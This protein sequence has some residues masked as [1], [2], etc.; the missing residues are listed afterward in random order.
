MFNSWH[1]HGNHLS[2]ITPIPGTLC[3]LLTSEGTRH[4]YD[5]QRKIQLLMCIKIKINKS[6]FHFNLSMRSEYF[7]VFLYF[8]KPFDDLSLVIQISL[9]IFPVTC[10]QS[11]CDNNILHSW[12]GGWAHYDCNGVLFSL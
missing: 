6:N 8:H 7:E 4:M 9:M 10:M 5:T 1:A 12:H 2:P 3:S 11:M